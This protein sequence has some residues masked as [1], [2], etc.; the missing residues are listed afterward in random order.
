MIVNLYG[1]DKGVDEVAFITGAV[2]YNPITK[3]VY[4]YSTYVQTVDY[5]PFTINAKD[6]SEFIVDPTVSLKIIEGKK[7]L[8]VAAEAKKKANELKTQSLTP[9]VLEKMWIE[10]WDG[11]LPIYGQV[12]T[13]FKDISK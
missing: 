4:E 1:S 3:S 7:K 12:P 5:P 13:I 8:I 10:K 6:G 11:K 2:W 9:A